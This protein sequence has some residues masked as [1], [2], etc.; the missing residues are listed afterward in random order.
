VQLIVGSRE[1]GHRWLEA[2][3]QGEDVAVDLQL[4]DLGSLRMDLSL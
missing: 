3:C 4:L 2:H 1:E